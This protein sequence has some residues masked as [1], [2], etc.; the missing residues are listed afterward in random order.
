MLRVYFEHEMSLKESA[1]ALFIHKNTMQYQLDKI[2]KDTGYNPRKFR[3]AA[4]LY[5]G[6]KLCELQ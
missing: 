3:D 4:A 5:M 2:A 6:L 1:E